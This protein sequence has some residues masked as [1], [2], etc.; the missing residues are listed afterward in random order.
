MKP[1][2]IFYTDRPK[3]D[4]PHAYCSL[5]IPK[6]QIQGDNDLPGFREE[7]AFFFPRAKGIKKHIVIPKA[8]HT[9]T[10]WPH[11]KRV[12]ATTLNWFQKYL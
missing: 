5:L 11:R 1:G 10:T 2:K 9:F 6:L 4:V 3:T 8:D 7:F 12:L